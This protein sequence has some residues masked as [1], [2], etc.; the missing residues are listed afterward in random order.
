MAQ[1]EVISAAH[2]QHLAIDP[3][4]IEAHGAHLH[5]IPVVV[6]EFTQLI[7]QFP[8]VFTKNAETGQFMCCAMCGFEPHENL[9]FQQQWQGIYVP[10]QV[11]R[12][13]FF[14]SETPQQAP[15]QAPQQ[16]PQVC[17]NIDSPAV[18]QSATT[19]SHH[20]LFTDKGTPSDYLQQA[21][22]LLQQLLA[23]EQLNQDLIQAVNSLNLIQSLSL[24]ITFINDQKTRLN[25]LYTI[26]QTQLAA[27]SASQIY[28]LHQAG[29]LASIYTMINSLSHIYHLIERKNQLLSK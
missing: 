4:Q 22:Q 2:H 26:D 21:T 25:G 19:S 28:Q 15:H 23:G 6:T 1:L 14:L 3:S 12:Q 11:R 7:A 8:I 29:S 16:A 27:L 17:I 18:V 9:F 13:P 20:P 10:L 5:L 24:E